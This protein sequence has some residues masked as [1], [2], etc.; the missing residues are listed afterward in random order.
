MSL[1]KY[2]TGVLAF[3]AVVTSGKA[4]SAPIAVPGRVEAEAYKPGG[5]GV[6]YHVPHGD[7]GSAHPRTD[8]MDLRADASASGGYAV[9][10]IE[11]GQWFAYDVTVAT[12]G[13]YTVSPRVSAPW[14]WAGLHVEV[15]GVNVTGKMTI[16]PGSG[17]VNLPASA[18]FSLSAGTHTT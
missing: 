7:W 4:S 12:P 1:S 11:A 5:E 15:E 18:Q 9:S 13:R 8:S 6:G 10:W 3:L 14:E 17:W 2:A 16:S